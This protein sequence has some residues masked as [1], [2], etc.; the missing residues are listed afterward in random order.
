MNAKESQALIPNER[1]N[2]FWQLNLR[3]AGTSKEHTERE[4]EREREREER[5]TKIG[6]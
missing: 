6:K 1:W 3:T 4:R 5:K 2:L